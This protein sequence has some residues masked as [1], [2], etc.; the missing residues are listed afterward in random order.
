MAFVD[1]SDTSVS[2]YLNCPWMKHVDVSQ[3][4]RGPTSLCVSMASATSNPSLSSLYE[5]GTAI[6]YLLSRFI[7][8]AGALINLA[9]PSQHF[10]G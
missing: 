5:I 8:L 2:P 10:G 6:V 1:F 9:A 3:V 7:L 4:F